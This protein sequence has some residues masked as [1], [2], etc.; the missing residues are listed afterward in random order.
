MWDMKIT[1]KWDDIWFIK[2][3]TR[4]LWEK[5]GELEFQKVGFG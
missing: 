5:T 4:R 2:L 1:E 3:K